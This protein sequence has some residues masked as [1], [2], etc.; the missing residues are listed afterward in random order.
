MSFFIGL[1]A[2]DRDTPAD[3]IRQIFGVSVG[4]QYFY[5]ILIT[6]YDFGQNPTI[7]INEKP[8]NHTAILTNLFCHRIESIRNVAF[9]AG[10]KRPFHNEMTL[11]VTVGVYIQHLVKW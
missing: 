11:I 3:L 4:F 2:R 1:D 5:R 8:P 7:S 6:L 9:F 10:E